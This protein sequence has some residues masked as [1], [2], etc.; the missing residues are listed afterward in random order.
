MPSTKL[1]CNNILCL[2]WSDV[3]SN[4]WLTYCLVMIKSS[5]VME[6]SYV[7]I[8]PIQHL[9]NH[10]II[11]WEHPISQIWNWILTKPEDPEKTIDLSQYSGKRY[12]IILYRV[13][14]G[15]NGVRTCNLSGDKGGKPNEPVTFAETSCCNG[16]LSE[17]TLSLKF[18]I[19][20]WLGPWLLWHIYP[21]CVNYDTY[22]DW[23]IIT[24]Q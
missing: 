18:G 22:K 13:H 16:S 1:I 17:N 14:L 4:V 24:R 5:K 12:H 8:I 23:L 2:T 3:V 20:F 7:K 6:G 10:S 15:M 11:K 19:G 21:C 9:Q